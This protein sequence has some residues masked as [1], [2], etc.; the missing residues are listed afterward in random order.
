MIFIVILFIGFL[1]WGLFGREKEIGSGICDFVSI[2]N[3]RY[4]YIML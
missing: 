3:C 1:I 4:V 2:I